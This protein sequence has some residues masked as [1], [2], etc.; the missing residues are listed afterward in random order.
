MHLD[1]SC[2]IFLNFL[3]NKV[4]LDFEKFDLQEDEHCNNDFVSV[5]DHD[6]HGDL[7]FHNCSHL[8]LPLP[9]IKANHSMDVR[10]RTDDTGTA[11]G[12]VALFTNSE[13]KLKLN[14]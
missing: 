3:G 11:A 6:Y 9:S 13:L 14:D 2:F 5:H 1:S 10:F 12:F 7:I 4:K 8:P